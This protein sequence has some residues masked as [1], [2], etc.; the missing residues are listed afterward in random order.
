[1][2]DSKKRINIVFIAV[3]ITE[4]RIAK[5]NAT[6]YALKKPKTLCFYFDFMNS[7]F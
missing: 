2:I 6:L 4:R 5:D 3:S 7:Y 1:M